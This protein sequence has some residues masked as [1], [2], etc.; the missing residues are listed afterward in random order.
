MQRRQLLTS[1]AAAVAS[2]AAPAITR[3]QAWPA[4]SIRFIVPYIPGS[5]P[6]VIARH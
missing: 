3:A 2:V 4:K 1:A 5:A 6:D